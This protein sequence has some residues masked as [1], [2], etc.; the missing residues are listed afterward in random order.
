MAYI[1]VHLSAE[2]SNNA[3][4]SLLLVSDTFSSAIFMLFQLVLLSLFL[5]AY[6][7]LLNFISEKAFSR[8]LA[9]G[10]SIS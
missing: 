8:F 9:L 4:L 2:F 10:L 1:H 7:L 5:G 3:I 6:V